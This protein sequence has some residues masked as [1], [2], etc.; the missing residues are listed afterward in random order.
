MRANNVTKAEN[1]LIFYWEYILHSLPSA[2]TCLFQYFAKFY[3]LL[4]QL[5]DKFSSIFCH[6]LSEFFKQS[7]SK[8]VIILNK[9]INIVQ[10]NSLGDAIVLFDAS[11]YGR[12][13]AHFPTE[14]FSLL[15]HQSKA[16]QSKAKEV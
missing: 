12:I 5:M 9:S 3:L 13:S 6:N 15:Q 8:I 14:I 11:V 4:I 7:S 2:T 1:T 10:L 16:K